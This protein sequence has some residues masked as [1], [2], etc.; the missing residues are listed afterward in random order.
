MSKGEHRNITTFCTFLLARES[1]KIF[2]RINLS[3]ACRTKSNFLI[4]CGISISA[5]NKLGILYFILFIFA[6]EG[7]GRPLC[8]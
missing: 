8:D 3:S 7:E 1:Y 4:I 6:F 5:I 2:I